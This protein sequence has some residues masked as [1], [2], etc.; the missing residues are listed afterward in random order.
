MFALGILR[1]AD[2]ALRRVGGDA[3]AA[4]SLHAVLDA[5]TT[6]LPW[7]LAGGSV[8]VACR[9][10]AAAVTARAERAERAE[11]AFLRLAARAID[12][13][14]RLA[15]ARGSVSIAA[16]PS[17][18]TAPDLDRH[19]LVAEIDQAERAGHVDEAVALLVQLADRFPDDPA[20]PGIRERLDAARRTAAEGH[21]ARIDAA[22]KVNDTQGV[23]DLYR[24]AGSWLE[25]PR[26]GELERELARWFLDV[27]HRRLRLGRI[28]PE[29]VDLATQVAETFAVTVEGASL[30]A[31]LPTL[32][33]S[34]GLC[35]RCAQPYAGTAAACP[36]CLS[37]AS[38]PTMPAADQPDDEPEPDG[39]DDPLEPG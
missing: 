20:L 38:A 28:Q 32:R 27:I 11:A 15:E 1:G 35:P 18:A 14:E 17:R 12:A 26:R 21:L 5:L 6:A 30:R 31:S 29:V 10:A 22:R 23:L 39:P 34:V 16:A 4:A 33:R 24:A 13:L 2:N 36:R 8:V 3:G 25:S 19:R 9:L 7:G 37:G